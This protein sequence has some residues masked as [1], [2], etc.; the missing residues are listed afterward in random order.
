[1]AA[2]ALVFGEL[3]MDQA[4]VAALT[5]TDATNKDAAAQRIASRTRDQ[6]HTTTFLMSRYYAESLHRCVVT[7]S[8]TG[9]QRMVR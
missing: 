7:V 2:V 9:V 4:D 6:N 1:M 5:G 3:T 8:M